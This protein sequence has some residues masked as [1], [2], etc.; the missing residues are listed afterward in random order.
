[1]W[2]KGFNCPDAPGKDVVK[3]LQSALDKKHI[4]VRVNA[5]LNDTVGTLLTQSYT[6]GGALLGAI[7]GT[8]T[9]GAYLESMDRI[10]KISSSASG[11]TSG[12]THMVINTEW[13]SFDNARQV[14]PTTQF[15]N[16]VDRTALRQRH[17]VFE[18]MI[19]GMYLGE[20]TR[21]VLLYLVDNLL[22]FSGYSSPTLNKQ[23]AFDTAYMSMIEAD[24]DKP[25]SGG[26]ETRDVLLT[27]LGLDAQHVSDRDIETVRKIVVMVGT[28]AARL[29]ATAV[30]GTLIQTGNADGA[31]N[32]VNVGF[33]GSL[34]ELYPHFEDR[35]RTALKEIIGIEAEKRVKF[36][37]A[38]DGS[39]VGAALGA[40]A[41]KKQA[42]AGHRVE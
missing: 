38:K 25:S 7:F 28:R 11:T 10:K 9:N 31:G 42:L 30:A 18:K 19:S 37:L 41:A 14:L 8:G 5:L 21:S 24:V 26:N 32:E 20:V 34:A 4:K 33:D 12:P 36:G 16:F 39:G 29:S 3:L 27:K 1:M 13:G 35:M 22:L 2:T 6:Q 17:H 15:D 23:Y 40:A